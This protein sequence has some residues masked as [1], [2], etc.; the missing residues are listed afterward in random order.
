MTNEKTLKACWEEYRLCCM[1]PDCPAVQVSET[2]KGFY[3]GAVS[4]LN[5]MKNINPNTPEDVGC[6]MLDGWQDECVAFAHEMLEE[7]R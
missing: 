6:T 7:A 3:A 2:K 5:L 1:H 4:F